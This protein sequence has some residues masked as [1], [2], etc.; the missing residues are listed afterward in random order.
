M[1]N[2][3]SEPEQEEWWRWRNITV[4]TAQVYLHNG[5]GGGGD[6]QHHPYLAGQHSPQNCLSCQASVTETRQ[7]YNTAFPWGPKTQGNN[8]CDDQHSGYWFL[9]S[10]TDWLTDTHLAQRV[11]S[12]AAGHFLRCITFPL[13]HMCVTHLIRCDSLSSTSCSLDSE[14]NYSYGTLPTRMKTFTTTNVLGNGSKG[15]H[16]EPSRRAARCLASRR[17]TSRKPW[18]SDT[19]E[20]SP[21]QFV[22]TLTGRRH[23]QHVS[24]TYSNTLMDKLFVFPLRIKWQRSWWQVPAT[25]HCWPDHN[26]T[27]C[28]QIWYIFYTN[29]QPRDLVTAL[30]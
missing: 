5:G 9:F 7:G 6:S 25:L 23:E 19:R 17:H 15:E 14:G 20:P 28:A 16:G 29:G 30:L 18:R 1:N 26:S 3:R 11:S 24:T 27:N 2:S 10:P 21:E 8:G 13:W 12:G 4:D 22:S